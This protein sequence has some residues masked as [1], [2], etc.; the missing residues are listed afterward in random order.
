[1]YENKVKSLNSYELIQKWLKDNF[2][3]RRGAMQSMDEIYQQYASMV[4][5][6]IFARKRSHVPE[7]IWRTIFQR[8]RRNYG[9]I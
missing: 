5:H 3:E 1:M 7:S 8:N 6:Y 9:K 4:Y 2:A